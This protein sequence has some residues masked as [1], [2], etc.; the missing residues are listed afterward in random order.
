MLQ[1][2]QVF[3]IEELCS[4]SPKSFVG[5]TVRVTGRLDQ[6]LPGDVLLIE[7]PWSPKSK[8]LVDVSLVDRRLLREKCLCQFI[9]EVRASREKTVDSFTPSGRIFLQARVGRV[10]DG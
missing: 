1:P 9:G 5:R 10:V 7:C 2:G 6:T 3:F 4:A 8:L